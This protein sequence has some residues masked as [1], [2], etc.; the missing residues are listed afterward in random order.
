MWALR[1]VERD[2]VEL[3][4]VVAVAAARHT[5]GKAPVMREQGLADHHV[6]P[7]CALV[8]V[9]GTGGAG[10]HT[11]GMPIVFLFAEVAPTRVKVHPRGA[12][13][14]EAVLNARRGNRLAR[15]CL[16]AALAAHAQRQQPRVVL[17]ARRAQHV[18]GGQAG[19]KRAQP[20]GA[21]HT[22][23][24]HNGVSPGHTLLF[25]IHSS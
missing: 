8:D 25:F 18:V 9:Q 12:Q 4:G 11:A 10:E 20:E 23:K 16:E 7:A 22:S 17:A 14:E 5:V 15:T 1:V 19:G 13:V 21:S 3:A 6:A 2:G 24:A